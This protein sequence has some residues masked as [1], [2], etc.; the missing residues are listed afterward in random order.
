MEKKTLVTTNVG[1]M[2]GS[3]GIDD[4]SYRYLKLNKNRFGI[5]NWL[6]IK[7]DLKA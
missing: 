7:T 2:L 4:F 3:L 5:K 6:K 1:R